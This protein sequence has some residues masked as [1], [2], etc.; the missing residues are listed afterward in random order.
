M[1]AAEVEKLIEDDL[2]E[3]AAALTKTT[4]VKGYCGFE[5]LHYLNFATDRLLDAMHILKQLKSHW[6]TLLKGQRD[7]A[8]IKNPATSYKVKW[9]ITD[10]GILR[11]LL[12]IV[13]RFSH[14]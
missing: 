1:Y 4:G 2:E 7:F 5:R 9:N 8:P 3:A 12:L 10:F 13:N 6:L 14:M 11:C